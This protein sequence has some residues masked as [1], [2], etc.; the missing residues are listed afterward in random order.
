MKKVFEEKSK[1]WLIFYNYKEPLKKIENGYG[2]YGALLSNEDGTKVQCHICGG[3]YEE[4]QAHVRQFHDWK[5]RDYKEKFQ[6]AYSTSLISEA[7][8]EK[9]K[10]QTIL[11]L[12]NLSSEEKKLLQKKR[13]E[14]MKKF[15]KE[16]SERKQPLLTLETKNKRGT[17]PDQLLDKIR[18]CAEA[19]G[20]SPSKREFIDFY[21]SQKYIHIIY[22]TFGSWDK[23]RKIAGYERPHSVG[24]RRKFNYTKEEVIDLMKL[25]YQENNKPPTETDCRRGLLPDSHVIRRL[26]GSLPQA[27]LEAGI[28][29]KVGRWKDY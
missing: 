3:L 7:I 11:W 18:K 15:L 23:A 6:L 12:N 20:H 16:R 5:I 17:C 1:N 13:I 21:Q 28:R 29:D 26:F 14:G 2:Y 22:R 4:L 25:F 19:I 27:R 8:R 10:M 9:R 24:K